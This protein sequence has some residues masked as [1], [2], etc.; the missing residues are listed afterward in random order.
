MYTHKHT[1]LAN[2][3]GVNVFFI[4]QAYIHICT[5][6]YTPRCE[7]NLYYSSIYTC[8]YM[9]IHSQTHTRCR[10]T[11]WYKCGV[12]FIYVHKCMYIYVHTHTQR[13]CTR[14]HVRQCTCIQ[15]YVVYMHTCTCIYIY[16]HTHPTNVLFYICIYIYV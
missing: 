14:T 13:Q 1:H 10:C 4:I 16:I 9:Y 11:P 12:S 5:Y 15:V 3:L 7:C 2:V 6:I 8:M